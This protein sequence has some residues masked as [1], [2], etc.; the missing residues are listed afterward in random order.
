MERM[1]K[2]IKRTPLEKWAD[3]TKALIELD[4]KKNNKPKTK[5][6]ELMERVALQQ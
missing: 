3:L 1:S 5:W 4:K 6:E 2:K